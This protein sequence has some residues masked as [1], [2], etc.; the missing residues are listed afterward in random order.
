MQIRFDDRV[1]LVTGAAQGIGRAIA[2]ALAQAGARVHLADLDADG[3]AASAKALGANAHVADL[4]SPEPAKELVGKV[5][6][7]EG[8]LDL[9]VN[10][11]GGVR[12]QVGRPIE[13][14]SESDWRAVFAANVDAAFFLSQAAAPAMKRAGYGRIVNISSGAGLRPSLTG[15]QAYASAKHALVGLTRQLAWEFGPDGIT[16]NSVAPGFVRSNP[17]TERQWESYGPEGQK[18]LIEGI[19][20]RRLGTSEDIAHASLFF[21]SE[22]AS[23]VTGQILSVDGGRS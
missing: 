16:V 8:R 15:I 5:L 6:G 17:A 21:L 7:A 9:L 18:R 10:A 11:A 20:T 1:A 23:W 13:E 19:H 14:I 3:V 4:G 22:Q 12:G 2:A